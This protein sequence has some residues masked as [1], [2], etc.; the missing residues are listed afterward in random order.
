MHKR[1]RYAKAAQSLF[2]YPLLQEPLP[3]LRFL[4]H[5]RFGSAGGLH[6]RPGAG[7][8]GMPGPAGDAGP[9]RLLWR[10]D[11]L[12]AGGWA[13]PDPGGGPR[14]LF[15]FGGLRNHPGGQPRRPGGRRAPAASGG[16]LLPPFPGPPGGGGGGLA[17]AGPP[18]HPGGKRP[19]GGP[20]PQGGVFPIFRWT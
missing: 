1:R 9:H 6:P 18:P 13:S 4:L 2:S 8:G 15:A 14:A 3:L 20:G 12:P 17:V 11:P 10:R 7:G 19:G 16:G 5:H